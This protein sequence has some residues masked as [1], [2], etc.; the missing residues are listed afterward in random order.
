MHYLNPL[1]EGRKAPL[2]SYLI[3]YFIKSK[4]KT[5]AQMRPG[6]RSACCRRDRDDWPH[7]EPLSPCGEQSCRKAR[8]RTALL[9]GDECAAADG[10]SCSASVRADEWGGEADELGHTDVAFL[11]NAVKVLGECGWV[12][13]RARNWGGAAG[14][15]ASP[16][17][18]A[19]KRFLLTSSP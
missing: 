6:Y 5:H 2:S 11:G 17:Y 1:S 12:A 8:R 3:A 13:A 7:V 10:E 9:G 4:H 14:L 16:R 19:F 15:T 18:A